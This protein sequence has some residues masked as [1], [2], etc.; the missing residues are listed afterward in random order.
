M[1]NLSI[2]FIFFCILSFSLSAQ[3]KGIVITNDFYK[4]FKGTAKEINQK[5]Q[6]RV[7]MEIHMNLRRHGQK[8]TG[9]YYNNVDESFYSLIGEIKNNRELVLNQF[10][11]KFYIIGTF[12]A[13]FFNE[14]TLVGTWKHIEQERQMAFNVKLDYSN[15]VE[16]KNYT[17]TSVYHIAENKKNPFCFLNLDYLHPVKYAKNQAVIP[18]AASS[19]EKSFFGSFNVTGEPEHDIERKKM[20]IFADY[21]NIVEKQFNFAK[22]AKMLNKN[23]L[24]IYNRLNK[25]TTNIYYNSDGILCLSKDSIEEAGGEAITEG[26]TFFVLDMKSGK[27]L[28]VDELFFYPKYK[29][30]MRDAFVEKIKEWLEVESMKELK[31]QGFDE[32]FIL[33]N[34][35]FYV[36]RYGLGFY[37]N[38][39]EINE[40]YV[41]VYFT[42]RE[43]VPYLKEKSPVSHLFPDDLKFAERV[44]QPEDMLP[45]KTAT[46]TTD[47]DDEYL[48]TI[49]LPSD[50]EEGGVVFPDD[51]DEGGVI[52]PDDDGDGKN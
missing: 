41:R 7:E 42:W 2:T 34:K 51:D 32:E 15:S 22:K 28:N 12:N 9:S 39:F 46:T 35:N 16:F 37:F 10:D 27:K 50:D 1:K 19:I 21:R 43:L 3:N 26:K 13:T 20:D 33:L 44:L 31:E 5:T 25:I 38:P 49:I 40:R 23:N 17:D 4:H 30:M 47:E 18:F 8:V 6:E 36:D 52:F 45:E 48:P 14:T 24:I 11:Y 29:S